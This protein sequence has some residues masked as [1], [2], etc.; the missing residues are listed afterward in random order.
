MPLPDT[1]PALVVLIPAT[2]G[3]GEL[4]AKVAI[5]RRDVDAKASQDVATTQYNEIIRRLD[6]IENRVNHVGDD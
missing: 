6:R 2:V 4:R 1:W 5:L 3:Y